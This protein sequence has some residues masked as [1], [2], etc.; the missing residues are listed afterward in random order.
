MHAWRCVIR[1]PRSTNAAAK[2]YNLRSTV[3]MLTTRDGPAV[4]DA[5]ARYWL[6]I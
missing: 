2:F 6:K 3:E 4:M 5:K 1:H